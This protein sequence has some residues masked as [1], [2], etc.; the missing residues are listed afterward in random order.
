MPEL[1]LAID[2]GTTSTRAAVFSPVGAILGLSSAPLTST[3]PAPGRVEQDAAKVWR[4]T[5]R[6]MAGALRAAGR[7]GGDIAAIGLTTQRASAVIW[8]RKTGQPLT[9]MV[10][11]SDLR[12]AGRAADLNAAG[13]MLAPQ[14]SATKLDLMFAGL[15]EPTDR[16]AWGNID[17]YILYRLTGGGTHA[18]DA[19]Q[20]W[21][22]GYL[23]FPDLGWNSRLI[24]H[25]GLDPAVFPRLGP[26]WG[27]LGESS[28]AILGAARPIS[29]N[30]ADQ[31]S[32]LIAHGDRPGTAKFT[33]GTSATFDLSTGG[34]FTFPGPSVPPL[35]VSSVGGD[36]R[37]C[38][39]GMVL[40]AGSAVDWL[41]SRFALGDHAAFT[42]LARS[43]A[44]ANGTAFL[45]ALQG[46]G[47][48]HGE[49]GRRGALTGLTASVERGHIARAG[50]EGLAFR[51]REVLDH[52]Y[53]LVD[54]P[55]P[56]ALGVDG[57]LTRS[58]LFLQ[59]L[60]DLTGRVVRRHATP[61]ATLLGAAICA[62]RGAELLTEA[63]LAAWRRFDPTVEPS[64]SS[65][66]SD[67]R[68]AA[69]RAAVHP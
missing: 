54:A 11:W 42:T 69:W 6:V 65:D 7:D 2:V 38:V 10:V 12:G 26:T 43:V 59:I 68:I 29:A 52:V 66:E 45:P 16:L 18:T 21:P 19:S 28:S 41:R 4:A 23:S 17:S 34:D 5:R 61:E 3:S 50:L 1:I 30:V 25:Q 20:A 36:T 47:A 24:D 22:S 51:A 53:T 14:Q 55:E 33:F 32:A 39:E 62:G 57:G 64:I 44:N 56:E 37:W 58:S 48:P 49:P 8:D 60:A 15:D 35:L 9:N 63:D 13:F 40:S 67:T 46:L 31:Q 27:V